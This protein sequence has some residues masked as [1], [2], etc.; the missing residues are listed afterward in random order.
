V[1]IN[2]AAAHIYLGNLEQAMNAALD[3]MPYAEASKNQDRIA[4]VYLTMGN[5]EY[6]QEHWGKALDY[7]QKCT[8]I[9]QELEVEYMVGTCYMNM[10][11]CYKN[12]NNLKQAENYTNRSI[13]ILKN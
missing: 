12:L 3:A 10:G 9:F 11:V 8:P 1:Y 5:I 7:F 2:I 6:Y 13:G 4:R